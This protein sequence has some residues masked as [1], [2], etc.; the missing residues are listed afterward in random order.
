[1]KV[2]FIVRLIGL[3]CGIQTMN[4][5]TS[6]LNTEEAIENIA[7]ICGLELDEIPH[8]D[9]INDVFKNIN[10]EEMEQIR[11][12]MIKRLIR[13]KMLDKYKIRNKYFHIVFD[14]TGLVTSRKK[15]NNNCL[16]KNMTDEKEMNIQNIVHMY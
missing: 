11:K 12:Y 14:G 8:C 16:I 15:Y 5:L 1:M 2:I 7:R 10:V 9:T 4:E 13:N 3:M 6:D